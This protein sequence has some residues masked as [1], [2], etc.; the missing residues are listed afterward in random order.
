MEKRRLR[1]PPVKQKQRVD[2][3]RAVLPVRRQLDSVRTL[4]PASAALLAERGASTAYLSGLGS[5]FEATMAALETRQAKMKAEED[6]LVAVER[7]L[8]HRP[9]RAGWRAR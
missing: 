1:R 5:Q 2:T 6:A 8:D 4:D 9:G 3:Y 7:G